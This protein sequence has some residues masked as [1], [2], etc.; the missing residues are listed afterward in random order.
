LETIFNLVVALLFWLSDITGLS[1]KA[2]NIV[3]YFIFTPFIFLHLIDRL[4][5]K[6]YLKIVFS[7]LVV[8]LLVIIKDFE[9]FSKNLFDFCVRFLQ[10]FKII[11]WNYT[12]ASV[13]ICLIV[14]FIAFIVLFYF[15]Y[16]KKI[17]SII[18]NI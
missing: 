9:K 6:H 11:G 13:I 10:W 16:R 8:I 3:V 4:I 18:D 15:A 7:I 2:I 5:K 14:P 1:Y 12:V 17:K